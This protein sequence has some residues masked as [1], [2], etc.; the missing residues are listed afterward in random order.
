MELSFPISAAN[1]SSGA[2]DASGKGWCYGTVR[3]SNDLSVRWNTSYPDYSNGEHVMVF[4]QSNG[5]S[6]CTGGKPPDVYHCGTLRYGDGR[7]HPQYCTVFALCENGLA[8]ST[9]FTW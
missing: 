4:A 5:T 2:S 8:H 6:V 7:L 9:S 1:M 3:F